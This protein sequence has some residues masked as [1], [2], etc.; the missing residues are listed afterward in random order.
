[1]TEVRTKGQIEA[2]VTAALTQFERDHLGR[3]PK[4]ARTFILQ[5][6]VLVRLKGILSPAERQLAT[7]PGGVDAIKTIRSRLI[8]SSSDTL[9]A[10]VEDATGARVLTMHTDIS[11][12]TGERVFLFGLD[13]DLEATLTHG[14]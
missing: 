14:A 4:E 11:S 5:D 8:E 10:I 7:E 13:R 12:R 2:A 6:L 9:V 3:G 1:M